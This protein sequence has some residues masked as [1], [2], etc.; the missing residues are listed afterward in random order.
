MSCAAMTDSP[1]AQRRCAG[2]SVSDSIEVA[3]DHYQHLSHPVEIAD[4]LVRM[5]TWVAR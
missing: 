3:F 2:E 5:A 1:Q 4:I